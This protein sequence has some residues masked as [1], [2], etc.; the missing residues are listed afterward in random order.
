MIQLEERFFRGE[1]DLERETANKLFVS[2]FGS[3]IEGALTGMGW[4]G[5]LV[6]ATGLVLSMDGTR[7]THGEILVRGSL[8]DGTIAIQANKMWD[9]PQKDVLL[10]IS[11]LRGEDFS[12]KNGTLCSDFLDQ[13]MVKFHFSKAGQ[14]ILPTDF[15]AHKIGPF[16]LRMIMYLDKGCNHKKVAAPFLKFIVIAC[17]YS[18]TQ[19]KELSAWT[20]G[21]AWPGIKIL[22]GNSTLF[23]RAFEGLWGA[24]ILP[25]MLSADGST[26][27]NPAYP[28]G[29]KLR[30]AIAELFRTALL[31]TACGSRGP[32]FRKCQEA[33]DH[34]TR[35]TVRQPLICWPKVNKPRSES[36]NATS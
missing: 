27:L 24:P 29:P 6:T 2:N 35:H 14:P 33:I 26:G 10:T 28:S 31:P 34:S 9:G 19:L 13:S 11:T 22:E 18:P 12:F 21:A 23:P 32:L 17:P 36:G 25:L 16:S 7:V 20:Q 15:G 1:K 30:Y 8:I 3:D 4:V 5:E